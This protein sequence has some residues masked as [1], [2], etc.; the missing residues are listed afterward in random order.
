MFQKLLTWIRDWLDKMI[1]SGTISQKMNVDISLSSD[2]STAL[3]LWHNMYLNQAD[4]LKTDV[5]SLGLPAAIAAE[6]ARAATIEME[7]EITGGP[8]AE[9]L[10][11][12]ME[13]VIDRLR[14][15]VEVGCA[16]GGMIIKPYPKGDSI[17]FNYV[18]QD[19][20]LPVEFDD[21]GNITSVVFVDQQTIK[22]NFYTRLE[23]H[24]IQDDGYHIVNKAFRS[25][26]K[27][28]LGTE[29]SLESLAQWAELEEEAVIVGVEKPLYGYFRY[30]LSNNIDVDSP[31]GISCYSKAQQNQV[32][33]IEQAD[34]Q[35]SEI[36]WEMDS[37]Q[38][39]LYVDILAFDKDSNDKPVLPD[40]RLYRTLKQSGQIGKSEDLFEE[41][42]PD[43]RIEDMLKTLNATKKQ[44]EFAC[45]LAYGTVSDPN[46]IEK[47]ATEIASA[48]QRSYSTITDV[49][50]S[51]EKCLDQ[52]IYAADIWT[53][54]YNLAPRGE[55]EIAYQFDDSI[56]TD[57]DEQ[58]REDRQDVD[59]KLM[60]RYEYRM[61][62]YGET[63]EQARERIAEI[64]AE[65]QANLDLFGLGTGNQ[66]T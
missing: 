9:F 14:D 7:F 39:A 5:Y 40:R 24:S 2:M 61:A 41:W 27:D 55:Y 20:F 64:D 60:A 42:S 13:K 51:L 19:A 65:S 53:T 10:N 12:N 28:T 21:D 22:N 48:K 31:L 17:V 62:T 59:R 18:P 49:Q 8:R 29:I 47:T 3:Q 58:R 35:W 43:I 38:R 32:R 11:T 52:L 46:E 15:E 57:Y 25:S 45:G 26:S 16:K 1:D 4:W 34:K 37:A 54:L 66:G 30:P 33:L 50:K 63:E 44:I 56:I 36:V 23:Y 6:I